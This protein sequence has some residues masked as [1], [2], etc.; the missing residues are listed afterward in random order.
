MGINIRERII[1]REIYLDSRDNPFDTY[2]QAY[3]SECRYLMEEIMDK[4]EEVTNDIK[5]YYCAYE[6][7]SREELDNFLRGCEYY[8]Y[9]GYEMPKAQRDSIKEYPCKIYKENG[10][11]GIILT[12]EEMLAKIEEF[13]NAILG[14]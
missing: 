4:E 12:Q 7:E 5:K 2:E 11:D 6:I 10:G 9:V 3:D 13:K 14:Q 8:G 1:K